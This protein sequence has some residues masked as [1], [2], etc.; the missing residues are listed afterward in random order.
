[1]QKAQTVAIAAAVVVFSGLHAGAQTP[2]PAAGE[3]TLDEIRDLTKQYEDV[4]VA[5]ADGYIRD[6]GNECGV[7][8]MAGLPESEGAMGVHYFRPD[9]LGIS[10]PPNPRVDGNGTYTDFHK[11]A[12]LLYEPQKDGS[13]ALIA[14]ENLA[15][16][17]AWD[18][19]GNAGPPS[20]YGVAYGVM[21]DDPAT[22][23]DEAHGFAPHYDRHVWVPR[24]N[25]KG[26]FAEF[27]P[28]VTCAYHKATQ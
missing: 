19:A 23:M 5:L 20:F 17:A 26:V 4:K 12:I 10:G 22:E 3:P 21:Q 14:V 24:E 7:A 1:M 8:T 27:N 2:A 25:P 11:P 18:A 6:P 13:M 16:K 9:L 28:T 15:F